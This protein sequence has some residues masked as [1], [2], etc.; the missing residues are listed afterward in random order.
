MISYR[1]LLNSS[2]CVVLNSG[3]R[4]KLDPLLISYIYS[5]FY[6]PEPRAVKSSSTLYSFFVV[7][8][9]LLFQWWPSLVNLPETNDISKTEELQILWW[10]EHAA[11]LMSP[12]P[13]GGAPVYVLNSNEMPTPPLS[14]LLHKTQHTLPLSTLTHSSSLGVS[15][16]G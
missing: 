15:S 6:F 4:S 3:H 5:V 11:C 10:A 9:P 1:F 8:S 2:C 16:W 7:E 12:A 14:F 13:P